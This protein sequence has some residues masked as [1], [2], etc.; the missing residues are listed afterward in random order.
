MLKSK[1]FLEEAT[2]PSAA[3]FQQ[4]IDVFFILEVVVEVD[5]VFVPES[6]MKVN[7][8]V[9]LPTKAIYH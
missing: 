4:N 2:H 8:T 6:S 5:D 9:N 1:A 3:V 7:F